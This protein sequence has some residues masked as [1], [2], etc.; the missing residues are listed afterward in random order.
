M[1]GL[2][3][4]AAAMA[5]MGMMM[6]LDAEEQLMFGRPRPIRYKPHSPG[7][8]DRMKR[9]KAAKASRKRNR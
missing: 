2:P 9:N 8:H 4:G 6:Q 1:K 3:R 7:A 5:L